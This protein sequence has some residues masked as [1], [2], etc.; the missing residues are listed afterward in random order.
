[1][2]QPSFSQP[3]FLIALTILSLITLS[4]LCQIPAYQHQQQQPYDYQQQNQQQPSDMIHM[5]QISAL[6]LYKDRFTTSRKN[7][8]VPQLRCTGGDAQY[9]GYVPKVVSCKSLGSDGVSTQWKCEASMDD[10]YKFGSVHVNCEG[11]SGPGDIHVV[12]GSCALDYELL[13]TEKGKRMN[14]QNVNRHARAFGNAP[15][16]HQY[17][18]GQPIYEDDSSSA[19]AGSVFLFIL[20]VGALVVVL[21]KCAD[22]NGAQATYNSSTTTN[23]PYTHVP[24]YN[25]NAYPDAHSSSSSSGTYPNMYP[26]AGT[27]P[28]PTST[29]N[30]NTSSGIGTA[31]AFATGLG[32]GATGGFMAGRATARSSPSYN[33]YSSSSYSNR[34]S[35][36]SSYNSG[37][38]SSRSS[39]D[40]DHKEKSSE[41]KSTGYGGSSSR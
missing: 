9:S 32:L 33:D 13:F 40:D 6:T 35:N 41:H 31:T 1:M 19:G 37:Y 18:G 38:R 10:R 15:N 39:Y 28:Y 17:A 4:V 24:P 3:L 29:P 22:N 34:S 5:S 30:N 16:H 25:P 2:K 7:Q 27:P 21:Y 20:V 12:K 36:S 8:P 26:N 14:E 11:Y 23:D